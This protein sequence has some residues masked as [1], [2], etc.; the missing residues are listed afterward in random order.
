[1][2]G[3]IMPVI[4]GAINA[5]STAS[6]LAQ[7]FRDQVTLAKSVAEYDQ[8]V[9]KQA[10][11]NIS[12]LNVQRA[13]LYRQATNALFAVQAKKRT[14]QSTTSANAAATDTVGAS[15]LATLSDSDVQAGKA[16]ASVQYNLNIQDNALYEKQYD[17][18]YGAS[19]SFKADQ[20]ADVPS[21][22]TTDRIVF[23]GFLSGFM[24]AGGGQAVQSGL[25]KNKKVADDSD[26]DS[27]RGHS[28]NLDDTGYSDSGYSD[29]GSNTSSGD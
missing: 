24:G 22:G 9:M 21:R 1:M 28:Y 7:G 10:A 4:N 18:L 2:T 27:R 25:D 20:L 11:Q 29:S 3:W 15:V 12:T 23:Q 6:S 19:Q 16:V 14:Q 26:Y 8:N 13:A 5:G 17:V